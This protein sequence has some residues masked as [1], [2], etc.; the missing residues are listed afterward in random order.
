MK[1]LCIGMG[2]AVSTMACMAQSKTFWELGGSAGYS[3]GG[4]LEENNFVPG[5]H[6]AR[7]WEIPNARPDSPPFA[8]FVDLNWARVQDG[9][10]ENISGIRLDADL[11]VDE[12]SV[13]MG[14]NFPLTAQTT[15][16][17]LAGVGYYDPSFSIEVDASAF[18]RDNG[19]PGIDAKFDLGA[20]LEPAFGAVFGAGVT[21]KVSESFEIFADYRYHAVEFEAEL[22]GVASLE[23]QG[24]REQIPVSQD[25]EGTF[26]HGI[27][28]VGVSLR[29]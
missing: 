18:A 28:R 7:Q 2:I 12:Y 22:T 14:L 24:R 21:H 15:F 10:N 29:L 5:I 27:L 20:D 25:I 6:L 11:D 17:V 23:A 3:L 16:D 9:F 13:A 26:N 19:I 4:D 8:F 1:A